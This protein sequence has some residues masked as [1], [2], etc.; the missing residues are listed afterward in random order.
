MAPILDRCLGPE[1]HR[2]DW[3]RLRISEL[4]Y[5]ALDKRGITKAEF[6]ER[7]GISN[8]DIFVRLYFLIEKDT[9]VYN[10][11]VFEFIEKIF[12]GV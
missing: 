8:S 5:A 3:L 4:L 9:S 1:A 7:Y 11:V 12:D 2:K 10:E 6:Y